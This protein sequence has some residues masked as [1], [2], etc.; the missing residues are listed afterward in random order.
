MPPTAVGL[1]TLFYRTGL[2]LP[3]L[4]NNAAPAPGPL[5]GGP[6]PAPIPATT[7][8]VHRAQH[9]VYTANNSRINFLEQANAGNANL[10]T[11]AGTTAFANGDTM[12]LPFTNDHITSIRLPVPAPAGVQF[13]M[14]DN[15]SGCKIFVDTIAGSNDIIVYHANTTANTSGPLAWADFQQPA[16]GNTLDGYHAAARGDY[17]ALVLNNG[18]SVAMPRYFQTPGLEERRKDGQGRG[19]TALERQ[20]RNFGGNQV[21]RTRPAFAGG[22][23]VC[24]FPVAGGWQIYFQT[25]G[26]VQYARPGYAKMLFTLDWVGVHKRRTEGHESGTTVADM[27]VFEAFRFF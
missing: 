6:A 14:T 25:W 12:Y 20:P 18:G 13:F 9:T 22:C 11:I 3:A 23:F 10:R 4:L 27:H 8:I 5:M 19:A 26:S 7:P 21:T 24:G 2:G 1:N 15:L 16:A 17:P